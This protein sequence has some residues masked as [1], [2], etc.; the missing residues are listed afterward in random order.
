MFATILLLSCGAEPVPDFTV[1]NKTT[2]Y[3]V[4]NRITP[5]VSDYAA[6]YAR[7]LAGERV[8]VTVG[9]YGMDGY[10]GK[11]AQ[12]TYEFYLVDGSPVM[13]RKVQ[14]VQ[15]MGK[16]DWSETR[17][18]D[19]PIRNAGTSP[20]QKALPGFQEVRD[21]RPGLIYIGAPSAGQ[22]GITSCPPAG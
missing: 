6:L 18:T 9:V 4:V 10:P 1:T 3:V 20:R 8:T 19:A 2:P 22:S 5:R 11:I 13:E 15:A 12:G 16:S 17:T 21:Q 7:V 14:P